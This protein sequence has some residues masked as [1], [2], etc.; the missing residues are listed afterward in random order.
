MRSAGVKCRKF[1][2]KV[3]IL[4]KKTKV[5]I[6]ILVVVIVL[7][8]VG[9]FLN[10][11]VEKK[12]ISLLEEQLP[13]LKFDQ[14]EVQVFK[15]TAELSNIHLKRGEVAIHSEKLEV[16]G[17][18]YWK[19]I[20][21][22]N[23]DL[24]TIRIS[25]PEIIY[26]TPANKSNEKHAS[27]TKASS[28]KKGLE[29]QIA[30]DRLILNRGKFAL[31]DSVSEDK[32]KVKKFDFELNELQ[33]DSN[34]IKNKIPFEFGAFRL[35]ADSIFLKVDERHQMKVVRIGIEENKSRLQGLLLTSVYSKQEFQKHTPIEKDRY[36][37]SADSIA[38]DHQDFGFKNDSLKYVAS[39]FSIHNADFEIYR[40]KTQPDDNTVKPMYS[41]MLRKLPF[42]LKIDTLN[43]DNARIVYEE[44]MK[45]GRA[46]GKVVF[47]K[48]QGEISNL[49]NFSNSTEFPTTRIIA[50]A[51]F[52]NQAALQLNWA[53]KVNNPSDWFSVSGN[54]GTLSAQN[55]NTFLT[56]GMNVKAE[57]DIT[58]M[59]FN[60]SG[61][62]NVASGG[63]NMAYE[64]FKIEV[65][66]NDGTQKSGFLTTIANIFVKHNG[67]SGENVNKGLE[68]ERDK[69]KSFWNYLWSCIK[70][71]ALKTFT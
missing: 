40:D 19:F 62:R 68:I 25:D 28:K 17:L 14:L 30:V 1:Q 51:D 56:P 12:A 6:P 55:M 65:L 42:L 34:S 5:F 60:F 54:M 36:Q 29:K 46:P 2:L 67:D 44:R 33:I 7:L 4:N 63:L 57:G 20:F 50:K 26:Q 13:E 70:K 48:V 15:N 43:V 8:V 9:L 22:K 39:H 61:N 3:A 45:A 37:L 53:F 38:I 66:K 10:S 49:T 24:N 16:S 35:H 64:D 32:I 11:F 47:A 21:D 31:L 69:T 27:A 52:M 18:N 71:G 58:N 41:E 59:N 23:I